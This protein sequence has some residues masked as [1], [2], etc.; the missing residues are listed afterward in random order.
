MTSLCE[1][2][3]NPIAKFTVTAT[4]AAGGTQAIVSDAE[5]S[6]RTYR[7]ISCRIVSAS[8][9]TTSLTFNG[10]DVCPVSPVTF[11]GAIENVP[12]SDLGMTFAVSG[13]GSASIT[14]AGEWV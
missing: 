3:R 4:V 13:S 14:L 1:H 7:I 9:T 11:E 2:E 8:G 6:G 12:F 5:A 10:V